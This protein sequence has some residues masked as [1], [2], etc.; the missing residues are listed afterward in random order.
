MA[1]SSSGAKRIGFAAVRHCGMRLLRG[2]DRRGVV[3]LSYRITSRCAGTFAVC[4][5][6]ARR[7]RMGKPG[8]DI[9][10][11]QRACTDIAHLACTRTLEALSEISA[12]RPST[13]SIHGVMELVQSGEQLDG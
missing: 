11:A 13:I 5:L 10:A 8:A 2:L 12:N 1:A 3:P 4:P 9:C 7:A 6:S